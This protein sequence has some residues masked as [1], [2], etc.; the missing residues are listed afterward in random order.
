MNRSGG[1]TDS[2][3]KSILGFRE[4]RM[5]SRCRVGDITAYEQK[6]RRPRRYGHRRYGSDEI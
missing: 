4:G 5:S 6:P 3:F 1:T 2:V